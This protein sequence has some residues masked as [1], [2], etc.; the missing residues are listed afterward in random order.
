[1]K[2]LKK[3]EKGLAVLLL[4]FW[5][6]V[7]GIIA[8]GSAQEVEN[9]KDPAY[10]EYR[11][12]AAMHQEEEL[13]VQAREQS[14]PTIPEPSETQSESQSAA[15]PESSPV[16][17][18]ENP[19]PQ[20]SETPTDAAASGLP[21]IISSQ[22]GINLRMEQA[23]A[24][25][26]ISLDKAMDLNY[27]LPQLYVVQSGIPID[28][29]VINPEVFL[30]KDLR[31]KGSGSQPQIL[32]YHTHSQE[33]FADSVPGDTS[34][35]IVGVGDKLASILHDTYGYNVLHH[36]GIYDMTDGKLDR[37]PA[38]SKALP[39][40]QKILAEYPSIEL[41]IDLHRDGV[42]EDLRLVTEV[43]GKQTARLMFF[44]GLCRNESGD[45]PDLIHPYREQ[46]LAFS[47]QLMLEARAVKEDWPRFIYARPMRYNQHLGPVSAL[48]EVGA[49][50][51]TVEEAMNAAEP[52]ARI[53]DQVVG[54]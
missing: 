3:M 48:I 39:E 20:P 52:L 37:D 40:L 18:Q 36:T 4:Q 38:Y 10:E 35:T 25:C 53:I 50:T 28:S 16:H 9:P 51:N 23:L 2:W 54:K 15:P 30:K 41:V 14:P 11:E 6:P 46:N 29:S 1:M 7:F 44:N 26:G 12:L 34:Q 45:I 24:G 22:T 8:P 21:S 42:R 32:I 43:D 27:V 47:F 19:A 13:F 17:T 5:L 33:A 31:I 49:Q